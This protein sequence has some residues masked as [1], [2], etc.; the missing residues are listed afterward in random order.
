MPQ[1][2]FAYLFCPFLLFLLRFAKDMSKKAVEDS[3]SGLLEGSFIVWESQECDYYIS[4][5]HGN[6]VMHVELDIAPAG[7]HIIGSSLYFENLVSLVSYYR[8]EDNND[9]PCVLRLASSD[10]GVRRARS[11]NAI[12]A[13]SISAPSHA[14]AFHK[15]VQST[16]VL[17]NRTA[18]D[19]LVESGSIS[20]SSMDSTWGWTAGFAWCQMG[21]PAP[22]ALKGLDR[23][24]DGA[25]VIRNYSTDMQH[26]RINVPFK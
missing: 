7:V 25:F 23:W 15:R 10:V 26:P 20:S 13:P 17:R 5:V 12:A 21:K 24:N 4:I 16:P 14:P 1:F 22:A 9:L 3:L 2:V 6:K 11:D 8:Y 19:H 18:S